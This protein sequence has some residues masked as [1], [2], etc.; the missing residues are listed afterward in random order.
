MRFGDSS[1]PKQQDENGFFITEDVRGQNE[2]GEPIQEENDNYG[3]EDDQE[4]A[5]P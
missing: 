4:Q 5:Q 3:E 1:K 2:F